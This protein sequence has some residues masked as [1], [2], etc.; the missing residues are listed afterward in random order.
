[1]IESQLYKLATALKQRR[2]ALNLS[3]E[4]LASRAGVSKSLISKVENYRTI[5]SLPVVVRLAQGLKTN[6]S[7]LSAGIDDQ[8]DRQFVLVRKDERKVEE[9]EEAT[10]FV[11]HDLVMRTISGLLFESSILTLEKN[12]RRKLVSSDG[13]EFLYILQGS[14]DFLL[15]EESIR[16]QEGDAFLFDGRIPHV[17]RNVGDGVAEFLTIY[18]IEQARDEG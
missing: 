1:M 4:E 15:G 11:Y 3:L 12:A 7:E 16:L 18:L 2:K 8:D 10:G 13:Y 14:I 9:R 5:P 6:L 17:P